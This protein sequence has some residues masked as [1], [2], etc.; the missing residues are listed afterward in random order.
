MK[1][2]AVSKLAALDAKSYGV[3]AASRAIG[4]DGWVYFGQEHPAE[5]WR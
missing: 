2:D 3:E 5:G 4:S 1:L